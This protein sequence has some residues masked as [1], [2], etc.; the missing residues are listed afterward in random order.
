[1]SRFKKPP[2]V[3]TWISFE[4]DPNEDKREWDMGL[5]RQYVETYKSSLPKL[6]ALHE[7]QFQ[8]QETSPTEL[9]KVINQQ[10]R[11]Q[12]VRLSDEARSRI[13]QIGDDRL[14]FHVAK[15]DAGYLGYETIRNE[16][17]QKLEDYVQVFQPSRV[18]N[19]ALHY[20][21]I[22]DVPVPASGRIDMKDFFIG[23]ADLPEEPFGGVTALS[24]HFQANC[25]VD[26]GP[27]YME[28]ASLPLPATDA[29]KIFRFRME[30]HKQCLRVNTL[31]MA[32]VLNRLDVAHK[33][34]VDCFR[35]SLT[36]RTLDLFEPIREN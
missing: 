12:L 31:D 32:Q 27:L 1:M 16:A 13:L 4:F 28:V 10:V 30:W 34:L 26:P 5:L 36:E 11:L 8:M 17:A 22:I 9:P 21:D 2:V 23:S 7:R 35:R 14:S 29:A 15:T 25:P 3:E 18:Q 19:A 33:Y 24:F 6:E 20:L